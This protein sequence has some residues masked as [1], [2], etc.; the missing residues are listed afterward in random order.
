M[1]LGFLTIL[2]LATGAPAG[3]AT[4]PPPLTLAAHGELQCY[5]PNHANK[6]CRSLSRYSL[7]SG[8]EIE[9][10]A[11]V[12]I[13]KSPVI[14]MRTIS[15]V[16][17]KARR[18]CGR[19]RDEDLQAAVFTIDGR[20]ADAAN[21]GKLRDALRRSM[22]RFLGHEICTAYVTDG[23]ALLAKPSIDGVPRPDMN[24]KVIWVSPDGGFKVGA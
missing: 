2:L 6:T 23:D 7:E 11:T 20:P 16:E 9:N 19:V 12:L 14:T 18:V 24:Q 21:A 15:P 17:V 13:A 5:A 1:R 3:A 8:G 10:E 22:A 4:L